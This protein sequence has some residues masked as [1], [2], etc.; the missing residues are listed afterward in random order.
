MSEKHTHTYTLKSTAFSQAKMHFGVE[1]SIESYRQDGIDIRDCQ[2][3][4]DL[5]VASRSNIKKYL[6][7]SGL[8][9]KY[10]STEERLRDKAKE[11]DFIIKTIQYLNSKTDEISSTLKIFKKFNY[12]T[13]V[14]KI[15]KYA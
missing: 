1:Q 7:R 5:L 15:R 14:L 4:N 8:L 9:A 2:F 12:F 11:L 13:N 10:N 3:K 6:D